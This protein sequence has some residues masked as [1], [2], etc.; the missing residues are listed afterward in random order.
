MS[1]EPLSLLPGEQDALQQSAVAGGPGTK[2][3]KK[4]TLGPAAGGPT[5]TSTP[6]SMK[7]SKKKHTQPVG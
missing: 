6:A 1:A 5:A 3:H 7:S 4:S 2:I